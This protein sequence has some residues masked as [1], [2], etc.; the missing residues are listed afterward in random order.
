VSQV[1]EMDASASVTPQRQRPP[2]V[3]VGWW[4]ALVVG[5]VST[6]VVLFDG[7]FPLSVTVTD[8][9]SGAFP[10]AFTALAALLTAA[11]TVAF[12]LVGAVSIRRLGRC[13]ARGRVV[14]TV[15]AAVS[16]VIDGYVLL[17]VGDASVLEQV[18]VGV[19]LV[20]VVVALVWSWLPAT[21]A[22]LG[23]LDAPPAAGARRPVWLLV[24]GVLLLVTAWVEFTG[25]ARNAT[26]KAVATAASNLGLPDAMASCGAPTSI[27]V[28]AGLAQLS[29]CTVTA[30]AGTFPALVTNSDDGLI[31]VKIRDS[32]ALDRMAQ[33]INEAAT[34]QG[35]DVIDTDCGQ[36]RS[37][38]AY[39]PPGT[40]ITCNTSIQGGRVA[41]VVATVDDDAGN[42][43]FR[44]R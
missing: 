42:V 20:V 27:D 4:V 38:L 39:A 16:L 22:L 40:E 21:S 5:V 34:K 8:A 44:S 17:F 29:P 6:L 13:D 15:L 7:R 41:T 23:S 32:V 37:K 24:A 30:Q 9:S 35:V 11:V 1:S 2:S 14:L 43:T 36:S 33:S 31:D 18:L 12:W 10:V 28:L 3:T 25:S 26:E 19:H